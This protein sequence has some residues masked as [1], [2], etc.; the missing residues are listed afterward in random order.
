ML[1][2]Q[3]CLQ[4]PPDNTDNKREIERKR[5]G[6]GVG[7]G[8]G[9]VERDGLLHMVHLSLNACNITRRVSS[10]SM[11]IEGALNSLINNYNGALVYGKRRR[12]IY[13]YI[14]ILPG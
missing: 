8:E 12:D 7:K 14:Y 10:R 1:H 4:K 11:A 13:I 9:K 5:E 3:S 2:E 6:D